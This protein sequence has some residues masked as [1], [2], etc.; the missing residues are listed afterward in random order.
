MTTK[1]DMAYASKRLEEAMTAYDILALPA[2]TRY[3][4]L[5][6]EIAIGLYL[7]VLAEKAIEPEIL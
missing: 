6:A 1:A 7:R 2:R 4:Q 3:P 5:A